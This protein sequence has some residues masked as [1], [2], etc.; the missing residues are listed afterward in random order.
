MLNLPSQKRLRLEFE[1]A[2]VDETDKEISP[3]GDIDRG[4]HVQVHMREGSDRT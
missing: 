4:T 3:V 2:E 1:T